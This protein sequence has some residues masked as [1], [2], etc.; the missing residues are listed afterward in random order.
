MSLNVPIICSYDKQYGAVNISIQNVENSLF[1]QI[2]TARLRI[3][4]VN[5]RKY[6]DSLIDLYGD[7]KVNQLVGNGSTLT[8]QAVREKISRWNDRWA[9]NNPLSGYVVV[10][11]ESG[12]FVGQIILKPVKNKEVK[13]K[14]FLKGIAEIGYLSLPEH[15]GKKYG[16]EYTHAFV[17]HV[18]PKLMELAYTVEGTPIESVIATASTVNN[19][20]K[21]IL[22]K[23][24]EHTATKPRYG[25]MRDWYH[26]QYT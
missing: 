24:M 10:E 23:L 12:N 4:S 26:H 25:S 3:L 17:Y 16:Q 6:E 20:S 13:G 7:K 21:G 11:K 14:Q 19:A 18:L 2:D 1:I 5:D 8:P 22:Q 15:W 9:H